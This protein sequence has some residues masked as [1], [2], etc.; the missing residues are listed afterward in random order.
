MGGGGKARSRMK[1][2]AGGS[3][4]KTKVDYKEEKEGQGVDQI[5]NNI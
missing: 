4:G 5:D 2:E 1:R 3:E